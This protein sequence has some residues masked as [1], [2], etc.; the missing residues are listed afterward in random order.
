MATVAAL[1]DDSAALERAINALQSAGLGDDIIE[2]NE[3]RE[4]DTAPE[5]SEDFEGGVSVGMSSGLGGGDVGGDASGTLGIPPV[6]GVAG[7]FG[8]S[9]GSQPAP[10][11]LVGDGRG[12]RTGRLDRLGDDAEPFRLGLER[13]GKLLMLET[14]DVEKAVTTLREA[15]AQQ[16]YDP[17]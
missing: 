13:G 8:G 16:L 12:A 4:A 2:V 10:V 15:G 9:G 5:T 11:G 7:A 3:G 17:R 14:N 1:F 6:G